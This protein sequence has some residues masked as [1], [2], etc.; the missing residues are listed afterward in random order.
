MM[1]DDRRADLR[2]PA[3]TKLRFRGRIH[4]GDGGLWELGEMLDLSLSG[5]SFRCE[6]PL[7]MGALIEINIAQAASP[8][9]LPAECVRS[10]AGVVGVRF[11]GLED[12]DRE[13]L[14]QFLARFAEAELAARTRKLPPK[15]QLPVDPGRTTQVL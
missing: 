9:I 6:F 3:P 13:R 15:V 2:R 12:A 1:T 11:D 5:A 4:S 10:D 8:L 7:R 14:G